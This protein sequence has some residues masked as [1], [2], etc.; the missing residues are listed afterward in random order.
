MTHEDVRTRL[1]DYVDDLLSLQERH[2]VESHL[3]SCDLCG[4]E[5]EELQHLTR[6]ARAL[7]AQEIQPARD[8]WQEI[9][10]RLEPQNPKI[11]PLSSSMVRANRVQRSSWTFAFRIAAALILA[12]G[13]FLLTIKA[14][15]EAWEVARLEG[16]PRID[17]KQIVQSEQLAVGQWLE[18]DERSRARIAIANIGHAEIG[19]GS[20]LRLLVTRDTEHRLELQK[21]HMSARVTSPPRIFI[22][23]TPSGT[24]VDLGCAYDLFVNEAGNGTIHVTSGEVSMEFNG[25]E[26][27]VPTGTMCETKRGVGP[28]TPYSDLSSETMRHS[29]RR[30]DFEKSG[31]GDLKSILAMATNVDAI[32]LWHLLSRVDTAERGRVYDRF[33]I[34]IPPPKGVTREGILELDRNMLENWLDEFA[35]RSFSLKRVFSSR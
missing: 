9:V 27:F 33:A 14:P 12:F 35:A 2:E 7:S 8:L 17:D 34:L 13:S 25:V 30:F 24:A 10:G 18:T 6:R 16:T 26:S 29:L 23:E 21:G 28:G 11:T 22:V 1:N 31:K 32:T 3:Q 15:G 4:K 19:P 5:F 20:K